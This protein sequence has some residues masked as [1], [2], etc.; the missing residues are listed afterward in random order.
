MIIH[1]HPIISSVGFSE[2]ST[3]SPLPIAFCSQVAFSAPSSAFSWRPSV[4]RGWSHTGPWRFGS[5]GLLS[6]EL[7]SKILL[8][9]KIPKIKNVIRRSWPDLVSNSKILKSKFTGG[10]WK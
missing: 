4:K 3:I 9:R 5:L 2:D 8:Q 7:P 1:G 6:Q 10:A